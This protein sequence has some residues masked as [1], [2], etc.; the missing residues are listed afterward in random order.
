MLTL[1]AVLFPLFLLLGIPVAFALAL[2]SIPVFM[3]SGTVP[4]A[5]ALQKMAVATQSF[6]LLA[7]PF[8]ILAGNLMNATGI[9]RRL[10]EF[11][12]LLTGWMAG[13]LAQV[14]IVLSL[15]LGGIS[16]SAVAD[17]SMEARLFGRSMEA[18]GYS[19]GFAAAVIAFGF[20]R[21]R[22]HPAE[23]RPHPVRFHQ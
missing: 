7:V 23:Y 21:H 15:M 1:I 18:R 17:A 11:S 10:V 19:R 4:P 20:D 14:S 13:G 6:P 16:G 8:F 2:A 22:D 5:V 12:R 9:T 3:F